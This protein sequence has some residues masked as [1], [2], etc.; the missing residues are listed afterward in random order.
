MKRIGL[1]LLC[2]LSSSFVLAT[3]QKN[4]VKADVPNT[5]KVVTRPEIT[6]LWGMQIKPNNQCIEYYNFKAN[7]SVI[8][9]SGEEWSSGIYNYQPV[10]DPTQEIPALVLQVKYDNN[11]KD[12]SGNQEDQTGEISQYFVKWKNPTT[13]DFCVNEKGEQCFATLKRVLP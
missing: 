12:C 8:I 9:K 2:I 1:S 4:T 11:E 13:I 3:D 10:S 7:N 6:G 5:F